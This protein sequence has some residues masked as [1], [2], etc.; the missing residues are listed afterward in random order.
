[1]LNSLLV[2]TLLTSS[3]SSETYNFSAEDVVQKA[4]VNT[5]QELRKEHPQQYF[6]VFEIPG[7]DLSRELTSV[8]VNVREIIG[9]VAG[10]INPTSKPG[11][12]LFYRVRSNT[13]VYIQDA[14]IRLIY[15]ADELNKLEVRSK[16][17]SLD[18]SDRYVL[19]RGLARHIDSVDDL[20]EIVNITLSN[21][22]TLFIAVRGKS[23]FR[24]RSWLYVFLHLVYFSS[25]IYGT[26]TYVYR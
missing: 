14:D 13:S 21:N 17:L 26:V 5:K 22:N 19:D 3:Q 11:I 1:M 15:E 10:T 2:L 25:D 9:Y 16:P 20:E 6:R 12:T 8:D 7:P 24:S 18:I 4:I 23:T